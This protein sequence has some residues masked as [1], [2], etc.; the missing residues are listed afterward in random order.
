[1]ETKKTRGYSSCQ[2]LFVCICLLTSLTLLLAACSGSPT[3][4]K[5]ITP[6]TGT[7]PTT[8][9]TPT[10]VPMPPTQTSCPPAGT[11]RA[12]VMSRLVLG[13]QDTVVYTDNQGSSGNPI[14]G[15]VKRY[16]VSTGSTT[17][18]VALPHT[19]IQE[20]QVSA[21]GQWVLF[22]ARTSN[23]TA[24]QLVRLDGQG[25]QTLYCAGAR[26]GIYH[27]QWSP[28]QQYLAFDE[29]QGFSFPTVYLLH[30]A[31]GANKPEVVPQ[32]DL[33]YC[34]S[35]WL[36]TTHLYMV[37]CAPGQ[38]PFGLINQYLYL[39][40]ITNASVQQFPIT[41]ALC[42]DFDPSVDGTRLFTSTCQF[43]FGQGPPSYKGPSSILVQPATGG[44]AQTIYSSPSYAIRALRVASRSTFLIVINNTGG[45]SIDTS[46]N[47]MWKMNTDGTGL[48][49]LTSTVADENTLFNASTQSPWS[50]VS[51]DG[52]IYAV[53]VIKNISQSSSTS[54]L[55][56]GP[57]NGGASVTV[58]TLTDTAG[59]VEI[60]GW[61]MV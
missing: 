31:T 38:G 47:G 17:E 39:L 13:N 5:T 52:E 4:V 55:L 28:D 15:I 30:V 16:T 2:C 3:P 48:T 46:R 59:S 61:T 40:D 1:M 21:D 9:V 8:G 44:P 11:A 18:I 41:S 25:L 45:G 23:Q 19:T 36:D 33:A 49:R 22:L 58:A 6:T 57:M 27:L 12:A 10:T 29:M 14:T 54:S 26:G 60:V 7:T 50:N 34:L 24:I 43:V 35:V 37:A 53:K 20:A 32:K 51:R 56:V 42:R